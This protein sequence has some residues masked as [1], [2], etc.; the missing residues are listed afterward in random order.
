MILSVIQWKKKKTM[1]VKRG[2]SIIFHKLLQKIV[3]VT[4]NLVSPK[5]ISKLLVSCLLDP[6]TLTLR[7]GSVTVC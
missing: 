5:S 3:Q 4:K 2:D 1:N 6:S 7:H